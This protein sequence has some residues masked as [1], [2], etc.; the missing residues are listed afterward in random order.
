MTRFIEDGDKVGGL[1]DDLGLSRGKASECFT[2]QTAPSRWAGCHS[3][4]NTQRLAEVKF[5]VL[6]VDPRK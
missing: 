3:C 1:E 5:Y 4:L 6:L 2:S